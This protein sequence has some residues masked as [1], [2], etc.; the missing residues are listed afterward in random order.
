MSPRTKSMR[1]HDWINTLLPEEIVL[2]I[3]RRLDSKHTR[4]ACSLVCKRWLSL[5]RLSRTT[6]RIGAS[7]NPDFFIHLLSSRFPNIKTIHIDE[8]L[9]ISLPSQLGRKRRKSGSSYFKLHSVFQEDMPE[10]EQFDSYCLSDLGLITLSDQF[11]ALERL[12]LIWCSN[13]SSLGLVSLS[14]KCSLLKSLDLQGCYVG[15]GGLAAIGRCCKQLQ[16]LNLR[17]CEGLSDVGLVELAE[18]CSKSLKTLGV[19]ACAKITDKSLVAVGSHCKSLETLSL[20][21]ECIHND[22]V[23]AVAKG[24]PL[25]KVLKLQC[26]NVTDDALIAVGKYCSSLEALALYSFQRFTDRGLC[27]IGAGSKKLKN[28]TLSDC[29]F[30]SDQGLGSIATGCKELTH[31]EVNGCHNIG[32]VGLEAIGRSCTCFGLIFLVATDFLTTFSSFHTSLPQV[33]N[34]GIMAIGDNCKSLADL[35]LRFCDRLKYSS[36]DHLRYP[37]F[38]PLGLHKPYLLFPHALV[39]LSMLI[40]L[41]CFCWHNHNEHHELPVTL[42]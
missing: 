25:L 37:S 36:P 12:S 18:G 41:F 39:D 29:Y 9:S 30:L 13:V 5:E 23:L 4:D 38:F 3:F 17:F 21:S 32:S 33:G 35:S 15:D 10:A 6:L 7:G 14:L 1:C 2:E 40:E 22:G 28:L 42:A 31:L 20:D 27:A 16:E 34:K 19:A 11:P 24:C 26:I 8:R